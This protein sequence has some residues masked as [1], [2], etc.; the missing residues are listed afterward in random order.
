MCSLQNVF[1]I[2]WATVRDTLV[3]FIPSFSFELFFLPFHL[4]FL[5][6]S[7]HLR[8]LFLPVPLVFPCLLFLVPFF[9]FFSGTVRNT[10][11]LG[12]AG[13]LKVVQRK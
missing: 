9:L 1:S 6:L 4:R 12:S 7:V 2:V 10:G 13:S 8:F 11:V 3:L 5:F